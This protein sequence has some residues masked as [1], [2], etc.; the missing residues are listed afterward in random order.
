MIKTLHATRLKLG[1]IIQG[2]SDFVSPVF[3]IVEDE[4]CVINIISTIKKR[5]N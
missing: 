2:A 5:N 3:I 1:K 4:G